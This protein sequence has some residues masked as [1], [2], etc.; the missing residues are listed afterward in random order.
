MSAHKR[1]LLLA[2]DRHGGGAKRIPLWEQV[3]EVDG[4]VNP[5]TTGVHLSE[6]VDAGLVERDGGQGVSGTT[7]HL[8][9]EGVALLAEVR[10]VWSA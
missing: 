5:D 9:R 10:E 3:G 7:Y 6:L 8:T 4:R 1:D 2:I